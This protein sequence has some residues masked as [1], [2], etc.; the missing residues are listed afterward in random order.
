MLTDT[1]VSLNMAFKEQELDSNQRFQ[2][3]ERRVERLST[4]LHQCSESGT[5]RP[6]SGWKPD[7]QPL[8]HRCV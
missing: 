4:V 1:T 3:Y 6:K 8:G 2:R 7:A 5:I